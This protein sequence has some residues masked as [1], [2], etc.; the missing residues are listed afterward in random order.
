[1]TSDQNGQRKQSRDKHG[2][3]NSIVIAFICH[4]SEMLTA[5]CL[6]SLEAP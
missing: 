2:Q 4:D 3:I 6:G 1:M 5:E